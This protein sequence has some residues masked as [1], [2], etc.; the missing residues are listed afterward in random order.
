MT[1]PHLPIEQILA[2]TETWC[3]K[4]AERGPGY[5]L[6]RSPARFEPVADG[7]RVTADFQ[8]LAPGQ[9]APA[10]GF[11]FGPWDNSTEERGDA[12]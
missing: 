3:R 12:Q 8:I 11:V 9:S 2:A 7:H 4:A 1:K 10:T 6:Y 5:R